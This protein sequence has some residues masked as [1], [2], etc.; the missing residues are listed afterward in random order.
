MDAL[1]LNEYIGIASA[2]L[3]GFFFA[4]KKECDWLGIFIAAFLT[5]L[6]GG[7]MRDVLVG[8]PVY[9]FTHYMPVVLVISMMLL[10]I[11]LKLYKK[12]QHLEDKFIFIFTDA[13]DVVSFSIVGSI[14]SLQYGYNIFGVV[15]VAFANGVGGG[16]LRDVLLNEVPWLLRTG[17]YG[18]ISMAI[19]FIYYFMHMAGFTN[20]TC[21]MALFTFGIIFRMVAYYKKWHLPTLK[22]DI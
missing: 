17:L 7:I 5:A 9:S 10:A 1:L 22:E 21:V 16:I 12:R 8:R 2:A 18:S 15:L 13:I 11:F 20:M 14:V 3:S 6:G 19:G 4:V